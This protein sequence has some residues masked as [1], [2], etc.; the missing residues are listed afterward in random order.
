M[1]TLIEIPPTLTTELVQRLGR[2]WGQPEGVAEVALSALSYGSRASLISHRVIAPVPTRGD[3][4]TEIA[5]TDYG[6]ELMRACSERLRGDK[7]AD[8]QRHEAE[9]RLQ[10]AFE[11][12]QSG[13]IKPRIPTGDRPE[14]G[15]GEV[16]STLTRELVSRL[17]HLSG[18]PE[19]VAEVALSAVSYGSRASLI[20]HGVI[21]PIP[22]VGDDAVE[23][24]ITDYGRELID[25]CAAEQL[26]VE[27]RRREAEDELREA[28][29]SSIQRKEESVS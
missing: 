22:T 21:E 10:Q 12:W 23:V 24:V 28:Y 13:G 11:E 3:A 15:S 18:Q 5:I 6:R 27:Q 9:V 19:G 16:P 1:E 7:D 4:A 26:S 25:A 29:E 17:A 14:R 8:E 2:L 20:E